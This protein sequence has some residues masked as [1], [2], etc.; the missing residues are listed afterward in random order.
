MQL[1]SWSVL[2]ALFTV[3]ACRATPPRATIALS[4]PS[5]ARPYR[6][7][8]ESL[9]AGDSGAPPAIVVDTVDP[10]ENSPVMVRWAQQL[11]ERK[12]VIGVVGPSGS[13]IALATA[14]IYN[15]AGL[16]QIVPGATSRLLHQVGPWT[17]TLAPDDS[18]EG[19]FIASY[20]TDVV[21]VRRIILFYENDEFGQGLRESV[22]GAL[23]RSGVTIGSEIAVSVESDFEPLLAAALREGKPD[24]IVMAARE[25][26]TGVIASLAARLAPGVPIVASDGA[27]VPD[28]LS[29]YA[30]PAVANVRV[31]AFWMPDTTDPRQHRFMQLFRAQTGH[32]P[33]A[34]DAMIQDG[35]AL[36]VAAV[37]AVGPDRTAVREW[38][39]S[40][41]RERPPFPGL[42]GPVTFGT[43]RAMTLHMVRVVDGRIVVGAPR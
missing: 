8:A 5:W 23:R 37:R 34:S 28:R 36:L 32:D 20:L 35:I 21:R 25:R 10:S 29:Y 33:D 9:A 3:A 16:P 26:A 41:G 7:V 38:L 13:R 27:L 1:R 43:R 18:V 42:V 4:Y 2:A 6:E 19:A 14:P 31:V 39:S 11:A 40:L 22:A 15:A 12:E 17:F 30:G 24:A